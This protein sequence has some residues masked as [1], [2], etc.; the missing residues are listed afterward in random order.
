MKKGSTHMQNDQ[1]NELDDKN[2]NKESYLK[3]IYAYWMNFLII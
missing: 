1:I 3:C 2:V